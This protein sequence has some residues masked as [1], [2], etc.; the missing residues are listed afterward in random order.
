MDQLCISRVK[1]G[2]NSRNGILCT[3]RVNPPRKQ[4][5][6]FRP[7]SVTHGKSFLRAFTRENR[8]LTCVNFPFLS[9]PLLRRDHICQPQGHNVPWRLHRL[10]RYNSR[11]FAKPRGRDLLGRDSG[12]I[13]SR[14]EETEARINRKYRNSVKS[15]QKSARKLR[16]T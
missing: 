15:L 16:D 12:F 6:S 8:Y 14:V 9:S 11:N 4:R 2:E 7:R 10:Q 5:M 1:Y 3:P 13:G